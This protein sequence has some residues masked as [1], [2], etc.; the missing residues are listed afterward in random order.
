MI[1][2]DIKQQRSC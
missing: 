1:I 2:D